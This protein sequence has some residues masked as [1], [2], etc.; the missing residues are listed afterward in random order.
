MRKVSAISNCNS[1][2]CH[3]SV[4]VESMTNEDAEIYS[5]ENIQ[6]LLVTD[7]ILEQCNFIFHD[8][9]KVWK[10]GSIGQAATEMEIDMDYNFIDLMRRPVVKRIA[11]LHQLQ[12]M[13]YMLH[14][15]ELDFDADAILL[16]DLISLN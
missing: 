11:S 7:S 4:A 3:S 12:N 13:Y 2:T 14:G 16:A 9:F 1:H 5:V 15:K 6:P 8:Y 10:L